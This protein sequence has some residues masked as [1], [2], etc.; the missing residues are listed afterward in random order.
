[1]EVGRQAIVLHGWDDDPNSG[2]LG[3]LQSE[4]RDRGYDVLAPHFPAIR[5]REDIVVWQQQMDELGGQIRHHA[6]IIGHSLGCWQALRAVEHL[7]GS[8]VADQVVLVAGFYDAPDKRAR[9]FFS[10]EPKWS[11]L[12]AK[13]SKWVC[14]YSDDDEIVTPKRTI[15]L[16]EKLDAKLVA[17]HG[18]GHFLGSRGMHTFPELLEY[19]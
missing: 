5:K 16:A 17:L 18:F 13:A 15:M 7:P 8:V 1:M 10:P 4:L 3:W 14:L 6:L 11:V 19:L 2:W 9:E 12:Q